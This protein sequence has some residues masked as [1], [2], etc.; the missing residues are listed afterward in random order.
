VHAL[1]RPSILS[2][3]SM[4]IMDPSDPLSRN[5]Y[6]ISPMPLLPSLHP[7][8][9]A[10]ESERNDNCKFTH[11]QDDSENREA[12]PVDCPSN[13][14]CSLMKDPP[15]NGVTF[16]IPTP[17]GLISKQVFEYSCLFRMIA[18]RG[19]LTAYRYVRH[20]IFDSKIRR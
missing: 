5:Q 14:I 2:L 7:P 19:V 4:P 8:P 10:A 15:V 13:L 16:E 12:P 11:D 20:P 1:P 17:S 3:P 18:T 9:A 6:V